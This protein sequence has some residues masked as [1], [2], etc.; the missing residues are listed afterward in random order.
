MND[1]RDILLEQTDRLFGDTVDADAWTAADSGSLD[2]SLWAR[3]EEAGLT[4]AALDEADGGSDLGL[5][6]ILALTRLAGRHA[7]PGPLPETM[8]AGWLWR[9]VDG[10]ALAGVLG[11]GPVRPADCFTLTPDGQGWRLSGEAARVPWG[12]VADRLVLSARTLEGEAMLAVAE[13]VET[14]ITG[15]GNLANE[16]R[17]SL[18]FDDLPLAAD[19][20][21]PWPESDRGPTLMQIGALMRAQQIAGALQRVL[22]MS[23]EYANDRVQF[24]RPIAKFQ[25]VQHMLAVAAGHV[26]A[27][28]MAAEAAAARDVDDPHFALDVAIAKARAGEAVRPVTDAAHQVH[29]AMGFTHEHSL[30]FLTRRLWSWREEFGNE[31]LWQRE[32]GRVV[33]TTGADR[34]WPLLT[35][36]G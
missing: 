3:F 4:R 36:L 16:P 2:R 12:G 31:R 28:S 19:R 13:P 32:I 11:F 10:D 35:D 33:A 6:D 14:A 23:I 1:M 17:D 21:R 8:L 26:A 22:E 20:V 27:A 29:G 5:A 15:G 18:V 9:R 30:H 24:G 7:V 25:A 34:L